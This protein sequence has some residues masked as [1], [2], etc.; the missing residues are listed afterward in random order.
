MNL[1]PPI[2]VIDFEGHIS[3]GVVEYGVATIYDGKI[4]SAR[5]QV[6]R[7]VGAIPA[8]DTRLHRLSMSHLENSEPFSSEWSR[9][10][11]LRNTGPFA[12]H[13][14]TYE[15]NLLK[16]LWA[17]PPAV[18]SYSNPNS[19]LLPEWGPWLDSCQLAR[20]LWPTLGNYKL[21]SLVETLSLQNVLDAMADIL[22]PKNRRHFH[23]AL[24]DAL[25]AALIILKVM[26]TLKADGQPAT[27]RDLYDLLL[28]NSAQRE[29]DF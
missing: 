17:Y 10:V 19:P 8:E 11:D 16:N 1:S 3:Y 24:Y 23:A 5:T 26:D 22:C 18:P 14:A 6:C 13:N 2:H 29:L 21:A 25:A 15:H 28:P 27:A 4:V 7:P 12:A 20:V 9:F